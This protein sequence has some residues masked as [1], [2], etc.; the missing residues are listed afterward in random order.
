[1]A[2]THS[3]CEKMRSKVVVGYAIILKFL[4]PISVY[5][6]YLY[7]PRYVTKKELGNTRKRKKIEN[8]D[9]SSLFEELP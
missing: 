5:D 8:N 2:S 7:V 3:F 4:V 6:M 1:M 9:F